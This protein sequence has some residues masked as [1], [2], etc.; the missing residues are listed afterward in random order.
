MQGSL[1]S[2]LV[3]GRPSGAAGAT[4]SPLAAVPP[5]PDR[6][7]ASGEPSTSGR[8]S[9]VDAEDTISY[10]LS[11]EEVATTEAAFSVPHELLM[12]AAGGV[13]G[14]LAK[15]CTAPLARLT[16]LYQVYGNAFIAPSG[17]GAAALA[18][19][20]RSMGLPAALGHVIRTEGVLSLWKGNLLTVMHRYDRRLHRWV[21]RPC[22]RAVRCNGAPVSRPALPTAA[23]AGFPTPPS[24][25]LPTNAQSSF[26]RA[27]C[28]AMW[29]GRGQQALCRVWWRAPR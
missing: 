16:I 14:A 23:A 28:T 10:T 8:D 18:P 24:T 9:H 17:S 13:S 26:W 6:A 25:S 3:A 29:H 27:T 22:L 12:A 11:T 20:A 5:L 2:C 15:T 19:G 7:C 21:V 1:A 4:L